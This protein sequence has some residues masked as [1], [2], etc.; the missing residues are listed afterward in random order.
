MSIDDPRVILKMLEQRARKRFGQN[1]LTRP[2]IVSRIVRGAGVGEGDRVVEIGP[3]LGMLTRALLAHGA[4]VTAVE[5]DRDLAA[6]LREQIPEIRLVEGDAAKQH[7]AALLEGGGWQVVANLPFNVGTSVTLELL[8]N[9]ATFDRVTVM[10]QKEVVDRILADPGSR[11]YGAL[12]VQCAARAS[13][14]FLLEVPSSAFHPA[15]KVT[16]SVVRLELYDEPRTGGVSPRDFDKVVKAAFSQ[17]RKTLRNSLKGLYGKEG[18]AEGLDKAGIDG[19]R[20]A[21]TLSLAEF[22][23]LASALEG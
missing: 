2:D 17:R 22:Q 7:W 23:G 13:A 6:W 3:G 21:E 8:R 19:G 10:L 4:Q 16:A 15:P 18:A 1:F 20:R 11:T 14:A 9:P 12:T 5:L